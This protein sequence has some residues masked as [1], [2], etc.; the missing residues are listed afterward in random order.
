MNLSQDYSSLI[1]KHEING[2]ALKSMKN[3]EDW[4]ELGITVFG[5][6]RALA[7]AV[8]ELKFESS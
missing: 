5:H 1:F 6:V 7:V 3:K 8:Q 4:M 2:L